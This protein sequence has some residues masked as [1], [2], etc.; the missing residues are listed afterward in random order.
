MLF[1]WWEPSKIIF[2]EVR[3]E[4]FFFCRLRDATIIEIGTGESPQVSPFKTEKGVSGRV[5]LPSGGTLPQR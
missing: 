5:P 2:G 1:F 3:T 4:E